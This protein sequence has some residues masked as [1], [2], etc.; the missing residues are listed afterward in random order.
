MNNYHGFIYKTIFP[1]GKIYIGQTIKRKEI[2]YLGSGRK[3]SLA[4]V[5]YGKEN[6][7]REIL[8]FCF[9]QKQL[10]KWE[11]VYIKHFKSTKDNNGYNLD[12]GGNG[13][14]RISEQT[15]MKIRSVKLNKPMSESAKINMSIAQKKR[16]K[17]PEERLTQSRK[18]SDETKELMRQKKLGRKLT[19]EHKQ[20]IGEKSKLYQEKIRNEKR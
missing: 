13:K 4:I 5:K 16:F 18:F 7:K 15:K 19:E 1:N 20:K 11:R 8:K 6:I 14:G 2:N 12:F 9:N 17:N 10:D 3:V